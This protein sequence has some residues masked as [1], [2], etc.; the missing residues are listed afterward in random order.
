MTYN[1]AQLVLTDFEENCYLLSDEHGN[2]MLID[3]GGEPERLLESL[4]SAD[5]KL[6]LI[7]NTHGHIDHIGA[8]DALRKATGAQLAIHTADAPLLES[9]ILCGAA[10]FGFDYTP[11]T[12][13][14]LLSE[15]SKIGFGEMM[16]RVLHTPGHSP[17]SCCLYDERNGI[18]FSGDFIFRGGI[19]RWDL[20]G[21]DRAAM[22]QSIRNKF[23]P[24]P[25]EVQ[26][27]P[28][29]GAMTTVEHEKRTNSSV[30]QLMG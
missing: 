21:G 2:A 18:L 20:P 26:I 8:N 17:G 6:E 22:I 14:V 19:G 4:A 16:F 10:L 30:F 1:I 12:P 11:T 29:H 25:D 27:Y 3:P 15:G 5:L 13:D 9:E 28:G 23:L 24:L 7:V